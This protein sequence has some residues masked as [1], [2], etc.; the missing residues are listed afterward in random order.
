MEGGSSLVSLDQDGNICWYDSRNGRLTAIFS[1]N[2]SGWTLRTEKR[3]IS[4]QLTVNRDA[5]GTPR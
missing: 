3:S 2:P 5:E 1:L 4:G